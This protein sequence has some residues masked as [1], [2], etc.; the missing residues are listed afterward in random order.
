VLSTHVPTEDEEW[1]RF[2]MSRLTQC[3]RIFPLEP[4]V[5]S[6]DSAHNAAA[7]AEDGK[8]MQEETEDA[9][10]GAHANNE[11]S[12]TVGGGTNN[13]VTAPPTS[14]SSSSSSIKSATYEEILFQVFLQ[15]RRQTMRLRCPL[16]NRAIDPNNKDSFLPPLD[17]SS[18]SRTSFSSMGT[19]KGVVGWKAPVKANADATKTTTKQPTQQQL[20]FAKRLSQGLSVSSK[21]NATNTNQRFRGPQNV[22]TVSTDPNVQYSVVLDPQEFIASSTS[23]G[24]LVYPNGGIPGQQMPQQQSIYSNGQEIIWPSTKAHRLYEESRNNRI[25]I[26]AARANNGAILRQQIFYFDPNYDSYQPALVM[27][28]PPI[29]TSDAGPS[30]QVQ[31]R[32]QQQYQGSAER[33]HSIGDM[34]TSSMT[35]GSI[36]SSGAVMLAARAPAQQMQSQAWKGV[37]VGAS[38][39]A[40]AAQLQQQRSI[41]MNGGGSVMSANGQNIINGKPS[42]SAGN[43]LKST[44]TEVNNS[45]LQ[46]QSTK[47]QYPAGKNFTGTSMNNPNIMTTGGVGMAE[48]TKQEELLRQLFPSW[49]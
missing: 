13:S 24:S 36:N 17:G 9:E 19:G 34:S 26:E 45:G 31:S 4:K 6:A 40:A 10:E 3:T 33:R 14:S 28:M 32:Q 46:S 22:V 21:T 20:E 48:H 30:V 8:E 5:I 29:N 44:T 12:S 49:F 27:G 43:S 37:G 16:P 42:V 18:S 11:A 25:R 2:E 39:V 23:Q 7:E 41:M 47:L 1:L 38:S 35:Q 15:D